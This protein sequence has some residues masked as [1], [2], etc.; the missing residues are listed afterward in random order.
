MI[1]VYILIGIAV[2]LVTLLTFCLA[3]GRRRDA[4]LFNTVFF[5][6]RGLHTEDGEAPE[7][8]LAAFERARLAG[9]GVELD[10]QFTSDRQIVV[11][12][13]K[14]LSRM[15]GVDKRVDELTYDELSSYT[16]Q[17]GEERIPL[18]T[19]ALDVLG[20]TPLLCEFKSYGAVSDTSLCEATWQILKNYNG[21]LL[22]ESFNPFM[23]RWFYKNQP[24]VTRGILSTCYDDV[25]DVTYWQG[26]ALG[27]LLT[28]FLMRPNFIA[29]DHQHRR[30]FMF[31]L[32]KFLFHP[33]TAAWTIT[34][35]VMHREALKV[36]DT[37]IFEQYYPTKRV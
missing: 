3:P 35:T 28:N 20:N 30:K 33:L 36:F 10:V 1:I 37:C 32:C 23:V 2:L 21:P 27:A 24:Q 14:D 12:H 19:D 7:N 18:L 11:F 31:R 26:L 25:D 13:D 5:A 15:C 16:L 29:F 8:S 34:D 17:G 9:Y 22:I 4:E 6:H